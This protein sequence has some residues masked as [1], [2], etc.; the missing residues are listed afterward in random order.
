MKRSKNSKIWL[1]IFSRRGFV[2]E[3]LA[4][5]NETIARKRYD[6]WLRRMNPDYDEVTICPVRVQSGSRPRS[7]QIE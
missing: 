2:S 3:I 4:V 7:T 5:R 6:A 1:T